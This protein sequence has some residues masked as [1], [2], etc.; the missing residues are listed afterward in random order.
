LSQVFVFSFSRYCPECRTSFWWTASEKS[1]SSTATASE[2]YNG[3]PC[4]RSS[5]SCAAS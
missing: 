3:A 5:S 4:T 1:S 2:A